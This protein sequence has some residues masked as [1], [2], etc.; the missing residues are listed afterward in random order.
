MFTPPSTCLLA[1]DLR[2]RRAGFFAVPTG[3]EVSVSLPEPEIREELV[4]RIRREIAA[5]TYETIEKLEIAFE[6]MLDDVE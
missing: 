2:Q 4:A 6:R 1:Q 3:N 5:G